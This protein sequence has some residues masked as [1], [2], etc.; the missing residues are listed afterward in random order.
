MKQI[1][2]STIRV[3]AILIVVQ[4]CSDLL[5]EEKLDSP[6]ADSYYQTPQGY[7]DLVNSS[8]VFTRHMFGG[9]YAQLVLFGTDLW[10]SGSDLGASEFNTYS[11][12]LEPGNTALWQLW[13]NFYLGIAATNT[14][15]SRKDNVTGMSAAAVNAK[16]A[17][18]YFLRAWYYHILVMHFGG[19]ALV[20]DE[21]TVVTTTATRATEAQVYDQIIED[22]LFAEQHLPN[23]QAN[24]GRATKGAAQALLARVYLTRNMNAEAATYARKVIN[25]HNYSLLPNFADLWDPTKANNSE[26]IWSIQFTTDERLNGSGSSL[27]LYFTPRYDLLPGMTRA[28]NYDRPFPRY[29]GS[30]FYFDLLSASR[31][32]D[33]RF[34]RSWRET[35]YANNALTLPAGMAIGDTAWVFRTYPVTPEE[36][37]AALPY[38]LFG[39]NDIYNG[40]TPTGARAQYPQLTKYRDPNRPAINSGA[41]SKPMPELRLGEMHLIAA[42]ALMKENDIPG[43]LGH[44]NTLRARAT[45]PGFTLEMTVTAGDLDIDFILDERARELG[46]ERL[47]WADLK[48]TGKLIERAQLYNPSARALISNKHLLRPIPTNFLDRLSNREEFGQNPGY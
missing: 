24:F 17:E 45:K 31:H 38:R 42:E 47:R 39:V 7:G 4:G 9:N 30:R 34:E 3:L 21:V 35:W 20:V 29:V 43:A 14:A 25:D 8:Y 41:G 40:E 37:A 22:L 48:R 12:A 1:F 33:N 2:K 23:T 44:L 15:I 5:V 11:P 27:F 26:A 46:G 36:K 13:Q 10:L 28:L 6:S 19:V 16:A 32:M 18:A